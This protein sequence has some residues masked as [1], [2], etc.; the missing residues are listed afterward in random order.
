MSSY[1]LVFLFLEHRGL[2]ESYF[3]K[4]DSARNIW[5]MYACSARKGPSF[6][7]VDSTSIWKHHNQTNGWVAAWKV[8]WAGCMYI[9][10]FFFFFIS[11]FYFGFLGSAVCEKEKKKFWLVDVGHFLR[12]DFLLVFFFFFSFSLKSEDISSVFK[13]T[14]SVSLREYFSFW[15]RLQCLPLWGE[16]PGPVLCVE[17]CRNL[18]PGSWVSRFRTAHCSVTWR[19]LTV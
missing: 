16:C 12:M 6:S 5:S 3:L 15:K 7:H 9:F 1:F 19:R 18:Q 11:V 17:T 10:T 4:T 8:G 14:K 13:R 2:P